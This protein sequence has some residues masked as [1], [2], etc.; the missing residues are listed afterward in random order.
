[1]FDSLVMYLSIDADLALR[2]LLLD[3]L[4]EIEDMESLRFRI[5][6]AG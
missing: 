2:G 4:D 1:M 3:C 5:L 6:F